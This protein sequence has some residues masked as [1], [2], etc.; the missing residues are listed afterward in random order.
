MPHPNRFTN[1]LALVLA[2]ILLVPALA[3]AAGTGVVIHDA[4][5]VPLSRVIASPISASERPETPQQQIID[6]HCCGAEP[7]DW[8]LNDTFYW[9]TAFSTDLITEPYRVTE[10]RWTADGGETEEYWIAPD[11]G[12]A[13]DTSQAQYLGTQSVPDSGGAFVFQTFGTVSSG[14]V[15]EP[16]QLYWLIRASNPLGGFG[17]A[18]TWRSST[19]ADPD[20][21]DPVSISQNFDTGWAPWVTGV[22]WQMEYEIV[23]APAGDFP[24]LSLTGSCPGAATLEIANGTPSGSVALIRGTVSGSAALPG[25]PCVGTEIGIADPGLLRILTV[26]G[27]GDF[28]ASPNLPSGACG[29]LVQAVDLTTCLQSGVVTVP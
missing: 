17:F 7:L 19:N 26:D 6:S 1:P 25:G 11:G 23:G 27:N 5:G 18:L 29:A 13:P 28:T 3:M 12:G 24:S 16:G 20:I 15:V 4:S 10:I 8:G 2:V 21:Q 9:A 14:A 22:N